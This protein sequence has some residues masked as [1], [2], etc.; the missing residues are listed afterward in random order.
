MVPRQRIVVAAVFQTA[1][2]KLVGLTALA[3]VS[4]PAG[5]ACQVQRSLTGLIEKLLTECCK[6]KIEANT[7]HTRFPVP[8]DEQHESLTTFL[9]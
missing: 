7:E 6:M 4:A 9:A 2:R 1:R 3:G 8:E 5:P